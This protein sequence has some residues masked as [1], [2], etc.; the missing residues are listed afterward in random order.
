MGVHTTILS[1]CVG[2]SP[3]VKRQNSLT[4]SRGSA[5]LHCQ[6]SNVL[7]QKMMMFPPPLLNVNQTGAVLSCLPQF[8]WDFSSLTARD[9]TAAILRLILG[10]ESCS[11]TL[12]RWE[13]VPEN[14]ILEQAS[15]FC[16]LEHVTCY[17]M[18]HFRGSIVR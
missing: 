3:L 15:E 18:E 10:T 8:P 17:I 9:L 7:R 13:I 12:E 16:Y 1:S 11:K 14:Q 6:V 4:S 5:E 2:V